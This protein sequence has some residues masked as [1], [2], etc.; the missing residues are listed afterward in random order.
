MEAKEKHGEP[1]VQLV[2]KGHK[3]LILSD[4]ESK[5]F[6]RTK[7][8]EAQLTAARKQWDQAL[9]EKQI[10]ASII[11]EKQ[12]ELASQRQAETPTKDVSSTKEPLI[13]PEPQVQP[14]LN[15]NETNQAPDSKM[16]ARNSCPPEHGINKQRT[17]SEFHEALSAEASPHNMSSRKIQPR[18]QRVTEAVKASGAGRPKTGINPDNKVSGSEEPNA[19]QPLE[20]EQIALAVMNSEVE[21]FGEVVV[22]DDLLD[23]QIRE[24]LTDAL[25]RASLTYRL[26]KVDLTAYKQ[27]A[28]LAQ[29]T[30][31]FEFKVN[32]HELRLGCVRFTRQAMPALFGQGFT[33]NGGTDL[34]TVDWLAHI[35]AYDT[36]DG[37]LTQRVKCDYESVNV[38]KAGIYP[39]VYTVMN[40]RSKVNQLVVWMQVKI[41]KPQIIASDITMTATLAPNSRLLLA[42]VTAKDA[43]EGNLINQVEID[44]SGVNYQQVGEYPITYHVQNSFGLEVSVTQ[45]VTIKA[46]TPE[47][48]AQNITL[49]LNRQLTQV[50][51]LDYVSAQDPIDGDITSQVA[52]DDHAVNLKAGGQYPIHYK[53]INSNGQTVTGQAQVTIEVPVPQIEVEAFELNQGTDL[54]Q[55][56]WLGHVQAYDDNDGDLS[57]RV[58]VFYGEVNPNEPGEYQVYYMV[59][60]QYQKQATKQVTI[61]VR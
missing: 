41:S 16:V 30:Q 47:L 18:G 37:D 15:V 26:G 43:L 46:Q 10:E 51:W 12:A 1:F 55:V 28:Q 27:Q 23:F 56:D 45:Q 50:N 49:K 44:D 5:S 8:E 14:K 36:H 31:Y 19:A 33:I 32:N 2:G 11:K 35:Q 59:R 39:I 52:V 53:V 54:E 6:P 25:K 38:T 3:P 29:F 17:T 7:V 20:V 40:S 60:N 24:V 57:E 13:T 42:Q 61:W 58:T 22:P 48:F 9:F 34:K 21:D 4:Q